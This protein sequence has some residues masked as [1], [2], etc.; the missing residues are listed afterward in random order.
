MHT[1]TSDAGFSLVELL[2]ATA[3]SLVVI[4]TAMTTF[5]DAVAMNDVAT[6]T[7]DAS[8][9]LRGGANFLVRDLVATGRLDS[10]RRD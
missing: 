2:V 7:A 10:D 6:N 9:N 4:G 1:K 8:Q 3:I 5:K